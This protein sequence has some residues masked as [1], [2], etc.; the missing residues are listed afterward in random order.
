VKFKAQIQLIWGKAK[1]QKTSSK[2]RLQIIV[3]NGTEST[4]MY[5]RMLPGVIRTVEI[6]SSFEFIFSQNRMKQINWN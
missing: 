6:T 1:S 2:Y 4:A 3:L 5:V